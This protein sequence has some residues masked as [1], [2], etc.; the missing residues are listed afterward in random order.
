[1]SWWGKALWWLNSALRLCVD[2]WAGAHKNTFFPG[3]TLLFCLQ[4]EAIDRG[5][6]TFKSEIW[7]ECNFLFFSPCTKG[8]VIY[9]IAPR[10]LMSVSY[11]HGQI[12]EWQIWSSPSELMNNLWGQNMLQA[13]TFQA[14]IWDPGKA[15]DYL[16]SLLPLIIHISALCQGQ[17]ASSYRHW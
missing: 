6:S 17:M 4:E 11:S 8:K 10:S 9:S 3:I 7:E 14:Q 16:A 1:M 13:L 12:R 5:T 15:R 2:D